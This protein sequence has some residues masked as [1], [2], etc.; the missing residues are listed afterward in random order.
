[1]TEVT[2]RSKTSAR[3]AALAELESQRGGFNLENF[4]RNEMIQ[5]ALGPRSSHL[6]SAYKTGT[7]IVGVKFAGGVVLGADTRATGGS[8]VMDKNCAK[9]HYIARNMYCCGAGTAADTE[10]TTLM[11]ASQLELLRLNTGSEPRVVTANTLLKRLLHRYQGHIGAALILGGVDVTG[12]HL[13]TIHPHGSAWELPYETMGSGSL[14]AMSVLETRFKEEM[15]EEEAI[16]LVTDAILAGVFNDLGSGSNVDITVIRNDRTV[17][18]LRNHL[19]PN[20]VSEVRA[21]YTRPMKLNIP[22][23]TTLVIKESFK[24]HVVPG[25]DILQG[26]EETKMEIA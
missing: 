20:E 19:K 22:Q 23:G 17:S 26:G 18:K 3:L 4:R 13:Y 10:R 9:I 5:K 7:T 15:T 16:Q 2:S 8:E 14:A 24:P 12:A 1:M 6:P 25:A 21:T 11:I